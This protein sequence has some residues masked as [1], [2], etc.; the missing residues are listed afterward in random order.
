MRRKRLSDAEIRAAVD[1]IRQKYADFMVRYL[2]PRY[3][4][5]AFEDRYIEAMRIRMELSLFLHAEMTAVEELIKSEEERIREEEQQQTEVKQKREKEKNFADRILE[6]HREKIAKYPPLAVHDEASEEVERLFGAMGTIER[7]L[8]AEIENLMRKAYISIIN[9]PR[10][11]IEDGILK[12]CR[13]GTEGLPNRL[14]RLKTLFGWFPR[15]FTEIEKEEKQCIL[16]AAF[17]LHDLAD[18]LKEIAS[19]EELSE[20]EQKDVEKMREYVHIV[21]DDFRLKEFRILRR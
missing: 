10:A 13:V 14:G 7:E 12:L 9:S 1:K 11:R 16:E 20:G 2:K 3:A 17:F 19:S 15:K 18:V 5:D 4:L 6:E 8:W 21:I